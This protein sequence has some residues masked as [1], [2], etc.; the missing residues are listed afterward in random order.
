MISLFPFYRHGLHP[1][2]VYAQVHNVFHLLCPS[3]SVPLT[4]FAMLHSWPA[5]L[6]PCDP[7]QN[8]ILQQSIRISRMLHVVG[9]SSHA[10]PR[11]FDVFPE[12]YT[13]KKNNRI[14]LQLTPLNNVQKRSNYKNAIKTDQP[15]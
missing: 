8:L 14:S 7:R 5:P 13:T 15:T 6:L 3:P 2:M 9:H 10:V 11:L 12:R 1:V 4:P